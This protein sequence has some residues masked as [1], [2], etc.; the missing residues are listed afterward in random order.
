MAVH[1]R[2]GDLAEATAIFRRL[3][4]QG[5]WP[6]AYAVN[7][8]LNAYAND[9]RWVPEPVSGGWLVGLQERAF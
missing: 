7:A 6:N 5:T 3:R 4:S 1:I 2:S 8:L 9:F